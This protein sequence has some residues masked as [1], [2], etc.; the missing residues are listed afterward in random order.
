MNLFSKITVLFALLGGSYGSGYSIYKSSC[1]NKN[2][3]KTMCNGFC[4]LVFGSAC[5]AFW[6]VTLGYIAGTLV[7]KKEGLYRSSSFS[8]RKV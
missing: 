2:I 6:P 3:T 8:K 5:G 4:G 7:V 1:E